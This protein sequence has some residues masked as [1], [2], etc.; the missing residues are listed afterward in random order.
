MK[1]RERESL[2]IV[3][4]RIWCWYSGA[5]GIVRVAPRA[6]HCRGAILAYLVAIVFPAALEG[7]VQA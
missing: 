3:P 7:Q 4:V 5:I 2:L 1:E 6:Q